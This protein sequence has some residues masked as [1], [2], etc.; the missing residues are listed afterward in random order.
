MTNTRNDIGAIFRH[1]W[2][3]ARSLFVAVETLRA[4][5]YP[6][7]S[8]IADMEAIFEGQFGEFRQALELTRK[9]ERAR[10]SSR[11]PKSGPTPNVQQET[12]P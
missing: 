10:N 9:L 4:E 3:I 8:D 5:E 12:R 11:S 6:P 1:R 7:E 2:L